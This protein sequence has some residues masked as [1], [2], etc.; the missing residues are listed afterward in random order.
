MLPEDGVLDAETCQNDV[1]NI[2]EH[3]VHLVGHVMFR[4]NMVPPSSGVDLVVVR[5]G[6]YF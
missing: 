3:Y 6:Y 4:T 2:Y 5:I 1:S